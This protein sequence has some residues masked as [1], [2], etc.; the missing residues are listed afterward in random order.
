M[1]ISMKNRGFATRIRWL[2]HYGVNQKK[3]RKAVKI[4]IVV[5]I[6]ALL[7][8]GLYTLFGDVIL[9]TLTQRIKDMF[10]FAG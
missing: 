1:I 4:L 7:L 6:G 9:P 5:V 3:Y 8:G 2:E 10:D